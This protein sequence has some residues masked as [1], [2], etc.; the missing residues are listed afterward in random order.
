[1]TKVCYIMVGVSGSGK[2]TVMSSIAKKYHSGQGEKTAVFSL[3]LCRLDFLDQI[4]DDPKKAYAEAFAYANENKQRFDAFVTGTWNR[5]LLTSEVLFVDNT[6]LTKKARA[7]WVTEARAKGFTIIAVNVM[8]PLKVV[9]E[10]QATR[11]DKSVPLDVVRDMYMRLQEVQ[12][13]EVDFIIHVDGTRA[14]RMVGKFHI[15]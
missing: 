3:D 2:S 6:N 8:T 10:R 12:A 15:A 11:P 9:M 13:D 4:T 14:D 7:R 5:C 1:M